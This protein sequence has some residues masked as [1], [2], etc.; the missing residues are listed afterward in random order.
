MI[1]AIIQRLN[2]SPHI[3]GIIQALFI[4]MDEIQNY[5]V[6]FSGGIPIQSS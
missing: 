5:S 1:K 6:T 3:W 2:F 4:N